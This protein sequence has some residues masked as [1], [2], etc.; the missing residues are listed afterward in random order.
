M[1]MISGLFLNIKL[2]IIFL[3]IT[4]LIPFTFQETIFNLSSVLPDP[5]RTFI[6]MPFFGWI[7][8]SYIL[9]FVL[10]GKLAVLDIWSNLVHYNWQSIKRLK[11]AYFYQTCQKQMK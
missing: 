3:A 6:G 4:F 10:I 2:L 1:Q 11:F 8:S 7:V 9:D 5:V